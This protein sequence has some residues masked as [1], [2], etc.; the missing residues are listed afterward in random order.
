MFTHKLLVLEIVTRDLTTS[1]STWIGPPTDI[2]SILT[3]TVQHV[4]IYLRIMHLYT[5]L[6]NTHWWSVFGPIAFVTDVNFTIVYRQ[7][8]NWLIICTSKSEAVP[9]CV[10][11]L[12]NTISMASSFLV[13][14]PLPCHNVRTVIEDFSQPPT[15]PLF[16]SELMDIA[17]IVSGGIYSRIT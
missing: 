13:A 12:V 1:S 16:C 7:D 15:Y 10:P 17:W 9:G 2:G 5:K 14:D 6:R 8:S 11:W 3:R 4:G